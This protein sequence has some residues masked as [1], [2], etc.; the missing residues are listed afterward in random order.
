MAGMPHSSIHWNVK[1]HFAWSTICTVESFSSSSYRRPQS[2]FVHTCLTLQ[3]SRWD[4]QFCGWNSGRRGSVA[5]RRWWRGCWSYAV[6]ALV[7]RLLVG[8][9]GRGLG[10]LFWYLEIWCARTGCV[11]V[12]LPQYEAYTQAVHRI[13][14]HIVSVHNKDFLSRSN[15]PY[16]HPYRAACRVLLSREALIEARPE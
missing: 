10:V 11:R 9:V 6:L 16:R 5:M 13:L 2:S 3:T 15:A 4:F 12:L 7:V 14:L 1:F 8:V